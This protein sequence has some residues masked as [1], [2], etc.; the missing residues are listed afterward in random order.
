MSEAG[1][2]AIDPTTARRFVGEIDRCEAE[3]LTLRGE[4]MARCKGVRERMKDWKEQA[5]TAG[6]PRSGLNFLLK[7]R[8]IEE[9]LK[10]LEA[11]A[12]PEIVETADMIRDALGDFA[13]LPL[14]GAAV[15]A[16]EEEDL[17]G[18]HQKDREAARKAEAADRLSGMT[19]PKKRGRPEKSK[20]P[21]VGEDGSDAL[22]SLT[23]GEE[24]PAVH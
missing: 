22:S 1:S 19:T 9:K 24:A 12:E 16:A 2:N 3:L 4:Y 11:D 10:S 6:I 13:D 5:A 20:T 7:R 17:L 15:A 8:K 14:G 21:L 18:T 23:D